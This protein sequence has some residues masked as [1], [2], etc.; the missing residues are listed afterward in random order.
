MMCKPL[1]WIK[2]EIYL[3]NDRLM[4]LLVTFFDRLNSIF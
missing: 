1:Q 2:A 3:D 4:I